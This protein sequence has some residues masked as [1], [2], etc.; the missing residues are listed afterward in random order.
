[1]HTGDAHQRETITEWPNLIGLKSL[2]QRLNNELKL[3]L[4]PTT[5]DHGSNDLT[6]APRFPIKTKSKVPAPIQMHYRISAKGIF[7]THLY[8][9]VLPG[10][11]KTIIYPPRVN[12]GMVSRGAGWLIFR[13][14]FARCSCSPWEK[15]SKTKC[16]RR[17]DINAGQEND[18]V[19]PVFQ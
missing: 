8:W 15:L 6:S 18:N 16:V 9:V 5:F 12:T 2:A 11:C 17:F 1:M 19:W 7:Q 10:S 14:W 13:P 4:E 3:G